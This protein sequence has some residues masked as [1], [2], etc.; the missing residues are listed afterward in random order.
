VVGQ[1]RFYLNDN[2]HYIHNMSLIFYVFVTVDRGILQ[3]KI[4]IEIIKLE[5]DI[6]LIDDKN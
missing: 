1:K 6:K 2:W 3:K 4:K 5:L